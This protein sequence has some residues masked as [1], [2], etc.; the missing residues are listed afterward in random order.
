MPPSL[1]AVQAHA[2]IHWLMTQARRRTDPNDFLE[3]FAQEL[4]A[5]G[6]DAARITTGVPIL[7][8]QIFSFSGSGNSARVS[9]SAL[10]RSGPDTTA[11]MANSPISDCL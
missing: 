11:T 1:V 10:Y 8:P 7:H 9:R 6:V 4:R 3:A 5:A 2:V